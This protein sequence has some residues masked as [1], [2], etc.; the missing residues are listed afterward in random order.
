MKILVLSDS[1]GSME[2][3]KAIKER[4]QKEC[5]AMIHCGD[6]E[7]QKSDP[8]MQ[9]FLAVR[10]NCDSDANYPDILVEEIGKFRFLITH[11]HHYNVKMT[12]LSL[13][14]KSSEEEADI[15]CFGHSHIAGSEMIGKTLF[16]NPGSITLPKARLE[17]T[18][19]ILE[20][21]EQEVKVT[22]FNSKGS[23]IKDLSKTYHLS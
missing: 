4:H 16:I 15:V 19:A 21:E 14:Y 3:L 2:G 18:Y 1:H 13:S 11:G 9:G 7:L 23:I 17:K 10:G 12:L 8:L 6:S 5:D 20:T 22:F